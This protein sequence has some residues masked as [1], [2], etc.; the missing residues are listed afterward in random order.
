MTKL[1]HDTWLLFVANMRTT[2]RTPVWIIMGLFQP[3]CYMLLFAPLL[4]SFAHV[5]GFPP[6]GAFNVF[7][8]GVLIMTA[9]FSVSFAGF[10]LLANL[11]AGVIERLRVTPVSRLALLLGMLVRDVII[12]LAQSTLLLALALVMGLRPNPS[13]L[14]LLLPLL[15]LIGLLMASCSYGLAIAFKDEN[16]LAATVNFFAVPLLLLSGIT[17]PLTLAPAIL[18]NIARINPFA[19]AVDASRALVNG[20]LGDLPV[21]QS[22]A[23]F[24]VLTALSLFWATCSIR[25]AAM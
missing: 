17:L 1:F 18:R 22:F 11:R 9:I 12:L 5:P 6:G 24:I 25:Q 23:I 7:T 20:N 2:V 13:G 21:W 10:G 8:P 14:L 4:D 19:Y 16:A 3:I 15:I